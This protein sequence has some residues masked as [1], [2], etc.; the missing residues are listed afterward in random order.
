MQQAFYY[1]G[2]SPL[3]VHVLQPANRTRF[4]L[5]VARRAPYISVN[6]D[7]Q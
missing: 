6:S 7:P 3:R 5:G 2:T 4:A 1:S